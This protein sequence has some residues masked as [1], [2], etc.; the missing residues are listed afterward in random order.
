MEKIHSASPVK[1]HC[2][3]NRLKTSLG[4]TF[5]VSTTLL[6]TS[7]NKSKS[8]HNSAKNSHLHQA[9]QT[10]EEA[11]KSCTR[12]S[13]IQLRE[14][15]NKIC[16]FQ[17]GHRKPTTLWSST[18]TASRQHWDKIWQP[19][20]RKRL[21]T[22]PPLQSRRQISS[23]PRRMWTQQF[24]DFPRF[25]RQ[26]QGWARIW[27]LQ[28]PRS[29]TTRKRWQIALLRRF[30]ASQITWQI[31]ALQPLYL[32]TWPPQPQQPLTFSRPLLW[33][34]WLFRLEI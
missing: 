34:I 26:F 5:L 19:N 24:R 7:A 20:S 4:C 30:P 28:L 29:S 21:G 6:W 27:L 17:E 11:L 31:Q 33:M 10:S 14:S 32:A 9:T 2:R 8:G 1:K 16:K 15:R 25:T 3:Q 13:V 18:Q 22:A 12:Q 23:V